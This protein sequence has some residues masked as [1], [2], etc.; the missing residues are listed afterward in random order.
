MLIPFEKVT[1]TFLGVFAS[2]CHRKVDG[3]PFTQKTTTEDEVLYRH[4]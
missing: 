2:G 3:Y 4:R 1:A